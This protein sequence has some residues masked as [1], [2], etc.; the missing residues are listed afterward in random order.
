MVKDSKMVIVIRKKISVASIWV[1]VL[2]YY[3]YKSDKLT[4]GVISILRYI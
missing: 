2:R 1:G 4:D 3:L